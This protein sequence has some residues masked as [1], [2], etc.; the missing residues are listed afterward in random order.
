MVLREDNVTPM[1]WP[2]ARVIETHAGKDGLV[3]V[4]TVKT[5]T[6]T[7]RRPVVKVTLL[8]TEPRGGLWPA[9]CRRLL[10]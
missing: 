1:K 6:G 9:V 5:A 7:Y 3:R 4:V 8:L 2:L 10:S